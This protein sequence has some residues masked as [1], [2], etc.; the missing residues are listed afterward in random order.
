MR[1]LAL[2]PEPKISARRIDLAAGVHLVEPGPRHRLIMHQGPPVLARSTSEGVS[3][4]LH[5]Q[6][7][8]DM[9]FIPAGATGRWLDEGPSLV[10]ALSLC[11]SVFTEA[12]IR[13][14]RSPRRLRLTPRLSFRDERLAALARLAPAHGTPH[15]PGAAAFADALA[16][17]MAVQILNRALSADLGAERVRPLEGR[18]LR[19]V[20]AYI[21]AHLDQSLP[22]DDLAREAGLRRSHFAAAF[23]LA[24]GQSPR[25]FVI[26]RRVEAARSLLLAGCTSIS[27][28]AF[29]T[30]F[31]HQSHL[32]RALRRLTGVTPGDLI[33]TANDPT[34]AMRFS[35]EPT[36]SGS[37]PPRTEDAAPQLAVRSTAR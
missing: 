15:D 20:I 26:Q 11:P 27:E 6:R 13:L 34:N 10:L 32:S 16:R 21:D 7:A 35:T 37:A 9:D 1:S 22:L 30:G 17:A 28:V 19:S 5:L 14:G 12:A 8:G 23:R 25:Q 36:S 24:T 29:Q 33:R 31:A 4:A 2:S 18:R 3:T